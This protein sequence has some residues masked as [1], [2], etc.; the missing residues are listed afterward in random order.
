MNIVLFL[1]IKKGSG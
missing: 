1:Y